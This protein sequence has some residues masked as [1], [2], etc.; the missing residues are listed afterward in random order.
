MTT[1]RGILGAAVAIAA[2][3]LVAV[4]ALPHGAKAA[5][6]ITQLSGFA[7]S[8]SGASPTYRYLRIDIT[9]TGSSG[10]V[11]I[12]E[13]KWF[14]GA[15]EHPSSAMTSNSAPSPLVAS[16]SDETNGSAYQAYDDSTPDWVTANTS[17]V[18]WIQIDLGDGNGINPTS[19]KITPTADADRAPKDFTIEGSSTGS[20]SGEE[21]VL[22]TVTGET[23]T[24]TTE[25]TFSIP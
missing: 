7:V 25:E 8:S 12:R 19:V 6:G 14:V 15:A 9:D 5:L 13:I 11:G 18:G 4:H 21:T 3:A 10:F 17:G 20:F 16:A 23:W 22:K 24:A 1:K 2:A